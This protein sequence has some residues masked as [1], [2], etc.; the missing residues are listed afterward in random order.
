MDMEGIAIFESLVFIWVKGA[1]QV[2]FNLHSR[3]QRGEK[4]EEE[5]I[6]K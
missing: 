3:E 2:F 6:S 4:R 1:V 5:Q